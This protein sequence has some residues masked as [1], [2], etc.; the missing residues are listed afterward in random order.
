MIPP[1]SRGRLIGVYATA[2]DIGATLGPLV[3]YALGITHVD[4]IRYNLFFE[5][6][7]NPERISMPDID[8]DFDD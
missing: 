4:P 5:R 8:I 3:A 2:G 6:F 7:L 1:G